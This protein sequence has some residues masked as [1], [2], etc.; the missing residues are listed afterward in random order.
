[1]VILNDNTMMNLEEVDRILNVHIGLALVATADTYMMMLL[2]FQKNR[3]QTKMQ[4]MSTSKISD[5]YRGTR[6]DES[7]V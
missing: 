2:V 5:Q 4:R 1:M 7:M 3:G 6:V